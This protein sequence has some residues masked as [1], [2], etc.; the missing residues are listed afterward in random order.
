MPR[1][2]LLSPSSRAGLPLVVGLAAQAVTTYL[3]LVLAGRSLGPVGFAALSSLYFLLTST[4]T[5]LFTPLEQEVTARRGGERARKTWDD[6]LRRRALGHGL[7]AAA[8]AVGISLALWPATLRALGDQSWLVVSLCLALPGYACWFASRGELAGQGHLRV[9][10]VELVVDGVARLVGAVA[11]VL[12]D[13][14]TSAGFGFLFGLSPWLAFAVAPRAGHAPPEGRQALRTP[15]LTGALA[16]LVV[17]AL[18]AQLLINAGPLVVTLLA[19][20]AERDRAGVYLAVLVV[21]RVPVFLFTAVQPGFLRALAEHAGG[22]RRAEFGHLLTLV[23]AA[24]SGVVLGVCVLATAVAP[25]VVSWLF[26]FD[27]ELSRLTCLLVTLAVGLF[28]VATVC[29]QAL[30][31]L[32]HHLWVAMGWLLGLAGL[33]IGT[34]FGDEVTMRATAGLITGAVVASAALGA[35]LRRE[36]SA[37]APAETGAATAR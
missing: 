4:A 9:Y 30:I 16:L 24:V 3:V 6:S 29:G 11:L 21:V 33:A 19:S 17:S 23:V 37:W 32:G 13:H 22:G 26:D 7:G 5:G 34:A 20:D 1:R 36:L 2:N 31:A 25:P 18:A 28:L 10:G 15:S 8:L 27:Q 14:A 35:L 12:T